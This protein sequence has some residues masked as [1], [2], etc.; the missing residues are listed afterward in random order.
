MSRGNRILSMA[1]ALLAV[2]LFLSSALAQGKK[3]ATSEEFF[4]ISSIDITKS[5]LVLMRPTEVTVL[6][7]V[8]EKTTYLDEKGRALHLNDLRAGDTVWVTSVGGGEQTQM[9][10]RIRKGP[11]TVQELHRLYLNFPQT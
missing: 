5:Q 6:M 8:L 11:M 10:L 3:A 1:G 2:G 7:Q 9:A 4:I